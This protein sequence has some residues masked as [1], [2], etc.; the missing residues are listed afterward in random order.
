[1]TKCHFYLKQNTLKWS[2]ISST[3]VFWFENKGTHILT[4]FTSSDRYWYQYSHWYSDCQCSE[5]LQ[6]PKFWYLQLSAAREACLKSSCQIK[7]NS[8]F[9][10]YLSQV[11]FFFLLPWSLQ[12]S[13]VSYF[14]SSVATKIISNIRRIGEDHLI[15]VPLANFIIVP[16]LPG[17]LKKTWRS[18]SFSLLPLLF[19]R[20]HI[21]IELLS[22][23]CK[24]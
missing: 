23:V 20:N 8:W 5:V 17:H 14:L 9:Y 3:L 16:W 21:A 6:L 11:P 24:G 10:L 22:L 19:S 15:S 18:Q 12:L 13:F 7:A 1:M 4:P 2:G